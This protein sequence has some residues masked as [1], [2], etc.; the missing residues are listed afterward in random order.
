VGRVGTLKTWA[1]R[2]ALGT[3]AMLT[4]SAL[5]L[6]GITAASAAVP[7]AG[8]ISGRMLSDTGAVVPGTVFAY[9][10][11]DSDFGFAGVQSDGSYT[12]SVAPGSYRVLFV[13]DDEVLTEAAPYGYPTTF[14]PNA[15]RPAD[16]VPVVVNPNS[17]TLFVNS[18]LQP[19]A[20]VSGS[21]SG[22]DRE[23]WVLLFAGGQP[24]V[25]PTD[26]DGR[27]AYVSPDTHTWDATVA[28]GTYSAVVYAADPENHEATYPLAYIG[29]DGTVT[30]V[31]GQA[32]DGQDVTLDQSGSLEVTLQKPDG[33]PYADADITLSANQ[34]AGR[35]TRTATTDADGH[36]VF[37]GLQPGFWDMSVLSDIDSPWAPL[38]VR[39]IL[40]AAGYGS[41]ITSAV[42][43]PLPPGATATPSTRT[44]DG[45]LLLDRGL[46]TFTV[47]DAIDLEG[48]S[49]IVS[50]D[51]EGPATLTGSFT[52]DESGT[53][54]ATVDLSGTVGK[55]SIGITQEFFFGLTAQTI[56]PVAIPLAVSETDLIAANRGDVQA[57][58]TVTAGAATTIT[59]LEA[60]Q[61]YYAW[62]FS[63]PTAGGWMQAD[64]SGAI[65]AI[66]PSSL[67]AGD[68][69][70]AL[71][72]QFW[73]IVG[74]APVEVLASGGSGGGGAGGS[75]SGTSQLAAT[76]SD[77][78]GA[79]GLA[80][81][82]LAAGAAVILVRRRRAA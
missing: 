62:W 1:R 76:G 64:A 22:P 57:P 4:G 37:I 81:L 67:G 16:A 68:H 7:D 65:T 23:Y 46:V 82:L 28:A 50:D 61:W 40:V 73:T 74:W 51:T 30:A 15:Q 14:Y 11:D 12:I 31:S 55:T 18:A 52:Q 78:L 19:A 49:Y 48:V 53:W 42:G 5:A 34:A 33:S 13:S 20:R 43:D 79:G 21:V 71:V 8:T 6:G 66:V 35:M 25:N 77:A 80:A 60:G 47:K 58:A 70:V 38:F 10:I 24:P 41:D 63:S 3:V 75:G 2:I 44:D 36:A 32:T 9:G 45:L 29:V 56:M 39:G 72:N 27:L 54:T 17:D 59:G 69:T 26:D